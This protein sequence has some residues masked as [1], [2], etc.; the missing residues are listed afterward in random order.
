MKTIG[1]NGV[2]N[3]FRHTHISSMFFYGFSMGFSSSSSSSSVFYGFSMVFL[4]FSY[5]PAV[6]PL[7]PRLDRLARCELGKSLGGTLGT[8]SGH[9]G[10]SATEGGFG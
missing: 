6:L 10:E 7:H 5:H 1:Y 4:W 9:R 2:H 8:L 3:I